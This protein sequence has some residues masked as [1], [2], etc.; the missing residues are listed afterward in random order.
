MFKSLFFA[1]LI[2][3]TPV[4]VVVAQEE[5]VTY[6]DRV[7]LMYVA[8]YG[9]PGDSG[10]LDFWAQQLEE[11]DGN[12]NAIIDSFGNSDEFLQ[13]FGELD[14]EALVNNVYRQ[15]FNRDSDPAG[16]A[17]YTGELAA[18]EITLASFAL[19]V[20]N[21]ADAADIDGLSRDN[22]LAAANAYSEQL[23]SQILFYGAAEITSAK[24]YLEGVD[25]TGSE[26]DQT[27]LNEALALLLPY[28]DSLV[29]MNT[30]FGD[31]EIELY[32]E[33]APIT[34]ANFLAYVDS[35]FYE[36]LIFHRVIAGFMIQGGGFDITGSPRT[37]LNPIELE[38]DNGLSNLRGAIAMAR[39]SVPDSATSQFFINHV[40]NFFLD[41]EGSDDGYAVF[42]RVISGLDVVDAI[43]NLDTTSV[44]SFQ[45]LPVEAVTIQSVLRAEPTA[46]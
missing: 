10:G 25:G 38:A 2:A 27:L 42:G 40:D 19:D 17:F 39:T 21:G 12:L 14:N 34:V 16:L 30:N 6:R 26:V 28:S 11:N 33:L 44:G 23:A 9:R 41:A 36:D 1:L 4:T 43:A 8:Y 29:V 18:G 20:A 22:K 37:T 7:Q 31:I 13:R 24:A 32:P 3:V 45:D 15:L 46:E 5:E 35:K